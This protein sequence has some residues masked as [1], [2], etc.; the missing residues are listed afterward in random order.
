VVS[1]EDGMTG[2]ERLVRDYWEK[3]WV[4]QDLTALADLVTEPVVRHT[5][6]GTRA[7]TL[8]ELRNRIADALR[9]TCGSDLTF[10]ALTVD[11]DTVWARITLRGTTLATMA[12]LTVTWLAQYRLEG[13][14]IAE[15]WVLHRSDLDWNA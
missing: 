5:G 2:A 12:P 14:K 15:M 1:E 3:I 7:L 8:S 13:A 4:D 6:E 9:T 10:E 11:G